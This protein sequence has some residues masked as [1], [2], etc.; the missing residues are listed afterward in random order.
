MD[1]AQIE[2]EYQVTD[3]IIRSPGKF[4]GEPV[5]A[6]EFWERALDGS[7]DDEFS[8]RGVQMSLFT[9]RASDRAEFPSIERDTYSIAIWEDEYGFVRTHELT[10]AEYVQFGPSCTDEA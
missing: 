5:Y 9:V 2:T 4:E 8:D 3:G 10:H 1:R 6:P 7:A